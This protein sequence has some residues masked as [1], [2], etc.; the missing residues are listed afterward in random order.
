[1]SIDHQYY[2]KWAVLIDPKDMAEGIKGYV[3]CDISVLGKGDQA[4]VRFRDKN[5]IVTKIKRKFN[6]E[7]NICQKSNMWD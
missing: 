2:H 1:M 4:K 5:I 3:K 6:Y 7:N